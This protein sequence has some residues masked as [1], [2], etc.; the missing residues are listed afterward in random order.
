[1]RDHF[2]K[3]IK[4]GL[5]ENENQLTAVKAAPWVTYLQNTLWTAL[6]HFLRCLADKFYPDVWAFPRG[7]FIS[8]VLWVVDKTDGNIY[9]SSWG[10]IF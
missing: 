7:T 3:G 9:P 5:W 10:K 1:M 4:N 6:L 8:L 2:A